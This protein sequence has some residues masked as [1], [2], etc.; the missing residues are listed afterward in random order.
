MDN[1]YIIGEATLLSKGLNLV[2]SNF[3]KQ[4]INHLSFSQ[5]NNLLNR[6]WNGSDFLW[7]DISQ[8]IKNTLK[9]CQNIFKKERVPKVFVFCDS[10]DPLIIKSFLKVGVN[11]YFLP[12]CCAI[13]IKEA[14][15]HVKNNKKY[16]DPKLSQILTQGILDIEPLKPSQNTLT[17]REKEILH[18]IIE[19][20][21]T[22]EIANKLFISFCTVE[23]HRLHLIQKMGVRNTAGLVREAIS[24]NLYQK[25]MNSLSF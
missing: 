19:E 24:K 4:T 5:I 2:L 23:T 3:E 8:E 12:Q 16:I 21:T 11:G 17:K 14:L 22:Q 10:K 6:D 25:S 20:Y 7:M 1:H 9:I 18:L 15:I 13:T